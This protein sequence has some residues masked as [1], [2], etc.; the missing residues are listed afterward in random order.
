MRMLGF[1]P[2]TRR[3]NRKRYHVKPYKVRRTMTV[4]EAEV[5]AAR[6]ISSRIDEAAMYW[7]LRRLALAHI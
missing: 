6:K 7:H 2:V 3:A 1:P 4:A 5:K